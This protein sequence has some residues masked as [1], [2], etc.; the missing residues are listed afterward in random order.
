ME[1][2]GEGPSLAI[3]FFLTH[4]KKVKPRN[5]NLLSTRLNVSD[6][7]TGSVTSSENEIELMY[8][9]Y[10]YMYENRAFAYIKKSKKVKYLY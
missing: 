5:D 10:E 4:G 9:K 6:P 1:E 7:R 3:D 8:A 2:E